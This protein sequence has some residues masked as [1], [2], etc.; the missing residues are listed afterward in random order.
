[1]IE[2][3]E[4]DKNIIN[5][6]RLKLDNSGNF[7]YIQFSSN[8]KMVNYNILIDGEKINKT[9]DEYVKLLDW[10]IKYTKELEDH[11]KDY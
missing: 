1:M 2:K 9:F 3:I 8:S 10:W 7:I 6:Y 4:E 5:R 11:Y